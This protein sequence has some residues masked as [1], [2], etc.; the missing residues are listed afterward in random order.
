M[1]QEK[2]FFEPEWYTGKVKRLFLVG[3]IFAAIGVLFIILSV[4]SIASIIFVMSAFYLFASGAFFIIAG[5][6]VAIL[7]VSIGRAEM[8]KEHFSIIQNQEN[9]R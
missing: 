8:E 7:G 6:T 9:I 2:F 4:L 5:T 3:K 1:M